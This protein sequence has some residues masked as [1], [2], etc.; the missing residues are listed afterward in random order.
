MIFAGTLFILVSI[1]TILKSTFS[2]IMTGLLS[3]LGI[4]AMVIGICFV[5]SLAKSVIFTAEAVILVLGITVMLLAGALFVMVKAL[6][7]IAQID[8]NSAVENL[9]TLIGG[10]CSVLWDNFETLMLL[11]LLIPG[12][13][14][15]PII[16]GLLLVSVTMFDSLLNSVNTYDEE[17]LTTFKTS[18]NKIIKTVAEAIPTWATVE[19]MLALPGITAM[20]L[21]IGELILAVKGMKTLNEELNDPMFTDIK[22]VTINKKKI[23]TIGNIWKIGPALDSML[24][25][26]DSFSL[27]KSAAAMLKLPGILSLCLSI[28]SIAKTVQLISS[29]KVP[30]GF[31]KDGNPTGYEQLTDDHFEKVKV[32]IIK[33]LTAYSSA[34]TSPEMIEFLNTK[35]KNGED[36]IKLLG[37]MGNAVGGMV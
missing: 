18:L 11:F 8:M 15:M 37:A 32:N 24:E 2:Q 34:M 17:T 16:I 13:I 26:L 36:N 33:I 19:F 20:M 3:L 28:G 29:M 14:A 7:M 21:V 5:L 23:S 31:D 1:S 9:S 30:T 4:I 10:I 22:T 6:Q 12:I 25:A 35:Y 27:V